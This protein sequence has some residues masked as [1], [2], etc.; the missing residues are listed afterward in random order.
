MLFRST[1][2]NFISGTSVNVAN[3]GIVVSGVTVGNSTQITATFTIAATAAAGPTNV[4][5]TTP[6]GTSGPLS[7]TVGSVVPTLTSIS[8]SN[9]V[10]GA[11]VSV[12]LTGTNFTSGATVNVANAGIAVSG[13]TVVGTTQITASFVIAA[14][15]AAG[16]ANATVTTLGGTSGAVTFTVNPSA[17]SVSPLSLTFTDRKSVV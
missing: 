11:T 2:T 8:P 3:A 17:I 1:G 13:V 9:G 12:T 14:N 16:P 15:A 5:V 10:Q 4:T 7:F 6:G